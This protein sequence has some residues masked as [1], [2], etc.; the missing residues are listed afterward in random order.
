MSKNTSHYR[1]AVVLYNPTKEGSPK[2]KKGMSQIAHLSRSLGI[3]LAYFATS[4]D[5][6]NT[7]KKMLRILTK[8]DLL[9]AVGGDGTVNAAVRALVHKRKENRA[10]LLVVPT[11]TANDFS[12]NRNGHLRGEDSL[13]GVLQ[14]GTLKEV[15]PMVIEITA[16]NGEKEE[17]I[18]VNNAGFHYSAQIA[19]RLRSPE[20]RDSKLGRAPAVGPVIQD[21]VTVGKSLQDLSTTPFYFDKDTEP[22][23]LSDISLIH[24]KTAA[25]RL[26][27]KSSHLS[28]EFRF[29][30]HS[31]DSRLAAAGGVS[32][33][34]LGKYNGKPV[35]SLTFK[36][37]NKPILGHTDGETFQV[38]PNSSVKIK[39]SDQKIKVHSSKN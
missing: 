32:K 31:G 17:Q 6:L 21:I 5:N 12:R 25:K 2:F 27:Y 16:P 30:P 37:G 38:A 15:R 24:A 19:E 7:Q 39:L 18:A 36:T 4:S 14:K 29:V 1:R 23:H 3:P 26:H 9:I 35:Q 11:G 13:T 22:T 34:L 33:M 20:H 28:P 10:S 8:H